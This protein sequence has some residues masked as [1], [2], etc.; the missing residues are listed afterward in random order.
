M[1]R[2]ILCAA[3]GAVLLLGPGAALAEDGQMHVRLG[4][5]NLQN[6][7]GARVALNRIHA[8]AGA[9]C[10]AGEE[11]LTLD[12]TVQVEA[13]MK[14]MTGKAVAALAAPLVTAL[15]EGGPTASQQTVLAAAGK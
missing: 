10:G 7:A 5:L 14:Q 15:F 4:D 11:K 12:R 9:F 2:A 3:M 1:N 13:C 6:A 8:S